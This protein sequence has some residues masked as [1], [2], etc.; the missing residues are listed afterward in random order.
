M[1]ILFAAEPNNVNNPWPMLLILVGFFAIYIL[2]SVLPQRKRRKQMME[3]MNSMTIGTEVKTIGG[4]LGKIVSM[5]EDSGV[6]VIN[7]GTDEA[8]TYIT[9]EKTAIYIPT[10][11]A[12]PVEETAEAEEAPE[13]EDA[14]EAEEKKS[15]LKD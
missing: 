6:Y 12:A 15:T 1:N 4:M 5:N 14:S 13:A 10:P 8:P 11:V 3:M 7:V 9:I 2:M